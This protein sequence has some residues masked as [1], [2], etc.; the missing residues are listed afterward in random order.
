MGS[1][2]SSGLIITAIG[3]GL[4]FAAIVFLWGIM[5]LLVRLDGGKT[6]PEEPP[7]ADSSAQINDTS[8]QAN[9]QRAAAAAVAFALAQRESQKPYFPMAGSQQIRT[10]QSVQRAQVL[11]EKSRIFA[12]RQSRRSS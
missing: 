10:W 1:T 8:A 9:K 5:A 11:Q 12:H 3:M 7:Q 2:F 6:T 4:V